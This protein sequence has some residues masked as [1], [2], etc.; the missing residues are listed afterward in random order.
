M[1]LIVQ[2]TC[3]DCGLCVMFQFCVGAATR[4]E[5]RMIYVYIYIYIYVHVCIIIYD[6][7]YVIYMCVGAAAWGETRIYHIMIQYAMLLYDVIRCTTMQYDV[8]HDMILSHY[9]F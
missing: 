7:L 4:G 9:S 1:I 6:I 3:E 8:L 5:T 2:V